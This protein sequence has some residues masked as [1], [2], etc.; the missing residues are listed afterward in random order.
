M[1]TVWMIL[2]VI[3]SLVSLAALLW[4]PPLLMVWAVPTRLALIEFI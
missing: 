2:P 1:F 3:A 4:T